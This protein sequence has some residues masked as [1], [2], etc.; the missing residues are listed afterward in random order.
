MT[1]TWTLDPRRTMTRFQT[2]ALRVL[3][4]SGTLRVTEGS[5]AVRATGRSPVA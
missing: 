2:N 4:L 5:G 3:N 1:S